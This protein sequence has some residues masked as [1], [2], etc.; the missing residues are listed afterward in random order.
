LEW[1]SWEIKAA[2]GA[3]AEKSLLVSGPVLPS[4]SKSNLWLTQCSASRSYMVALGAYC[5]EGLKAVSTGPGVHAIFLQPHPFHRGVNCWVE[6]KRT[7]TWRQSTWVP[8]VVYQV[9]TSAWCLFSPIADKFA[10]LR[11]VLELPQGAEMG[12]PVQQ[13]GTSLANSKASWSKQWLPEHK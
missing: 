5:Q 8:I 10:T 6:Y 7:E 3:Q 12:G 13:V 4:M 11:F 2:L 1:A 9:Q